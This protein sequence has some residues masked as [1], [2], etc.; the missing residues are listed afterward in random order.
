MR[1][2]LLDAARKVGI[3]GVEELFEDPAKG[4]DEVQEELK[5]YS[6]GISGVPHFVINDKY[7]L[8]G[9]QPPNLFMRAFEI[10]AKDGA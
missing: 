1:H 7:Q 9:G 2:V 10:A 5:K 3:E 4:V 6:S 8:S